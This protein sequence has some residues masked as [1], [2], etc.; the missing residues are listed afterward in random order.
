MS[1]TEIAR[2]QFLPEVDWKSPESKL[3]LKELSVAQGLRSGYPVLYF[4]DGTADKTLFLVSGW[5]SIDAHNAWIDSDENKR[6][7]TRAEKLLVVKD[8]KHVDIDFGGFPDRAKQVE[9]SEYSGRDEKDIN[10]ESTEGAF[11]WEA[12]G[13]VLDPKEGAEGSYI[14]LGVFNAPESGRYITAT[15]LQSIAL[16]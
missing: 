14:S 13:K 12:R 1:I 10:D 3:F 15:A 9:I 11:D 7:L 6:F 8:L 2:L 16:R 4:I 5:S